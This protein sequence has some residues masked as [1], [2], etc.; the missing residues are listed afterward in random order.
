M[1]KNKTK[2]GAK[3]RTRARITVLAC[4]TSGGDFPPSGA[5]QRDGGTEEHSVMELI[6]DLSQARDLDAQV[7]VLKSHK[8]SL[9]S[10]LKSE[11]NVEIVL[12]L[13]LDPGMDAL[14]RYFDWAVDSVLKDG[15]HGLI[16]TSCL[17]MWDELKGE[18]SS[19]KTMDVSRLMEVSSSAICMCNLHKD[20]AWLIP[21]MGVEYDNQGADDDLCSKGDGPLEFIRFLIE[22][23]ARYHE[24]IRLEWEKGQR[25]GARILGPAESCG[26][27]CRSLTTLLKSNSFQNCRIGDTNSPRGQAWLSLVERVITLGVQTLHSHRIIG[28]DV[29]SAQA[30]ALMCFSRLSSS[31]ASITIPSETAPYLQLLYLTAVVTDTFSSEEEESKSSLSTLD[32]DVGFL[33]PLASEI[34]HLPVIARLALLRGALSVYRPQEL[35]TPFRDRASTLQHSGASLLSILPPLPK[36]GEDASLLVGFVLP[37]ILSRCTSNQPPSLQLFAVQTLESWL[38]TMEVVLRARGAETKSQRDTRRLELE[39]ER[40]IG[41]APVLMSVWRHPSKLV[42]HVA[43]SLFQ[44]LCDTLSLMAACS[45]LSAASQMA[46]V[47]SPVI[48]V[49]LRQPVEHRS[50]YHA[51]TLLVP[52]VG[53]AAL[54]ESQE[55]IFEQL[56]TAMRLKEVS[57]SCCSCIASLLRSLVCEPAPTDFKSKRKGD[58][59]GA[60]AVTVDSHGMVCN[61]A[62]CQ[63]YRELWVPPFVR[64]LCPAPDASSQQHHHEHNLADYLLPEL[65]KVDTQAV[66]TIMEAIRDRIEVSGAQKVLWALVHLCLHARLLGVPGREIIEG[67]QSDKDDDGVLAKAGPLCLFELRAA[68]ESADTDLRL[69]ALTALT[70][71]LQSS[72]VDDSELS[73]LK[74]CFKLSMKL[75]AT[76]E[77]QRA[78]RVVKALCAR[79]LEG[80]R[81]ALKAAAKVDKKMKSNKGEPTK[82]DAAA[83]AARKEAIQSCREVFH[84]LQQEVQ[85]NLYPGATFDRELLGLKIVYC[86]FEMVGIRSTTDFSAL[87]SSPLETVTIAGDQVEVRSFTESCDPALTAISS[88]LTVSVTHSMLNAFVSS[89]DKSR[90]LAS[91]LLPLFP[92]PLPGYSSNESVASLSHWAVR[93]ASSPRQRESDAGALMVKVIFSVYALREGWRLQL[94]LEGESRRSEEGNGSY[95]DQKGHLTMTASD[96]DVRV[97][98]MQSDLANTEATGFSEDTGGLVVHLAQRLRASAQS[99]YLQG[100]TREMGACSGVL[101]ILDLVRCLEVRTHR[102]ETLFRQMNSDESARQAEDAAQVFPLCHGLLLATRYCV[103]EAMDQGFLRDESS[104]P[105]GKEQQKMQSPVC[106]AAWRYAIRRLNASTHEALRV[107]LT[108]VAEASTDVAFAPSHAKSGAAKALLP[109]GGSAVDNAGVKGPINSTQDMGMAATY[110]NANS[111][112]TSYGEDEG[113]GDDGETSLTQ[114]CVVGAWMLVKE[115]AATSALLVAVSPPPSIPKA[116]SLSVS[117]ATSKDENMQLLSVVEVSTIGR[118]LLSAL[119]RLK[120]MGAI[121]EVQSALN[122]VAATLLRYGDR[123][124]EL[125]CLPLQWM[126]DVLARLDS[127]KQVFILRRSA[128]F[129]YTFIALLRAEP[130]NVATNLLPLAL[131]RLLI[132]AEKGMTV[133]DQEKDG[134]DWSTCVHALNALR[135]I[136]VDAALGAEIDPYIPQATVLAVHGFR[137][138]QWG[139][140]N[141]SM[142]LFSSVLQRAVDN[143]KRSTASHRGATAKDFFARFPRLFRFLLE[144][145][146]A[147]TSHKVQL[148]SG[149]PVAVVLEAGD[150]EDRPPTLY[151]I[152]LLLSKFRVDQ[153]LER[154][155]GDEK[156]T[157]QGETQFEADLTLFFPLLEQASR[158]AEQKIRLAAAGALAALTPSLQVLQAV[159][160]R[161]VALSTSGRTLSANTLHGQLLMSLAQ[162]KGLLGGSVLA[163]V[164]VTEMDSLP[165]PLKAVLRLLSGGHEQGRVV[166]T[167]QCPPVLRIYLELLRVLIGLTGDDRSSSLKQLQREACE[168]AL[169]PV[170]AAGAEHPFLL[171]YEPLLWKEALSDL[172]LAA[173]TAPRE[174]EEAASLNDGSLIAL[175]DHSLSEVR[176]G[177]LEGFLVALQGRSDESSCTKTPI[178][179]HSAVILNKLLSRFEVE[180]EAPLLLSTLELVHALCQKTDSA[181]QSWLHE[182][183]CWA[184][185]EKF[186]LTD[187]SDSN[188]NISLGAGAVVGGALLVMGWLLR[189]STL[190]EKDYVRRVDRWVS[191]LESAIEDDQPGYIREAAAE[192]LLTSGVHAR[193]VPELPGAA[194][195]RCR[196]WLVILSVLQDEDGDVR[197]W[198]GVYIE[199]NASSV[200]SSLAVA[201]GLAQTRLIAALAADLMQDA[202]DENPN[203]GHERVLAARNSL[204]VPLSSIRAQLDSEQSKIGNEKVFEEEQANLYAERLVVL[205][206][207]NEALV[208]ANLE[209]FGQSE[210]VNSFESQVLALFVGQACE[211]ADIAMVC[212]QRE[213]AGTTSQRL[214]GGLTFHR[215]VYSTCSS[216]LK[217]GHLVLAK[218]RGMSSLSTEALEAKIT[219]L[220][221]EKN[222]HPLLC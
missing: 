62:K 29:T 61:Q 198:G 135:L 110:L 37:G 40:V 218:S 33:P 174:S 55:G 128:G 124:E 84:W 28:K 127:K 165:A 126:T 51:I 129:A 168:V 151:P 103:Q 7:K 149:Q 27:L 140:R 19:I 94:P 13:Y 137:H 132:F 180:T 154:S 89:W 68:C 161:L 219:A 53:A 93:L 88:F 90:R 54:V 148:A 221:E 20:V 25:D 130:K 4:V 79:T 10:S 73:I 23:L 106:A 38:N 104:S 185:L 120:H 181:P 9:R 116:G 195:L 156:S 147:V 74:D 172:T 5:S 83:V 91:E 205:N 175:L 222:T 182:G 177:V 203:R 188:T 16:R 71:S 136:L 108:V 87:Y 146:A 206:S 139:V 197:A 64:M 115:A 47:W 160:S 163:G 138:S 214:S 215:E 158:K 70:A 134:P 78:L 18:G 145:L 8:A 48:Q 187:E 117:K 183:Q 171:P 189:A 105:Q 80:T 85:S 98:L 196:L 81:T 17:R 97:Q 14:R 209:L 92:H 155:Q 123:C 43:S 26:E 133:L 65:L 24:I 211:A 125:S 200:S 179:A 112:A 113:E 167:Y 35:D 210:D 96:D 144:E 63:R 109:A 201:D 57:S 69:S 72:P 170:W 142:M 153:E 176:G 95:S 190:S 31:T 41:I 82:D 22:V 60:S 131:S 101:A 46:K 208:T 6:N 220:N 99:A 164:D 119:G 150:E 213:G 141:S 1:T 166:R 173:A 184:Q 52:R 59:S 212:S 12:Q 58:K 86:T 76:D 36:D 56:L 39:L 114:M 204:L 45:Q 152:L 111:T 199:K 202:R 3:V 100:F 15:R 21:G 178:H 162:C 143:D 67:A 42:N 107:A 34:P 191:V 194:A 157:S 216:A 2:L 207:L 11:G 169:Y 159:K 193:L 75:T 49:A 186:V 44:R 217:A 32:V 122:S 118:V 50:R 66:P 30:A 121:A 192:A 77:C 102:L